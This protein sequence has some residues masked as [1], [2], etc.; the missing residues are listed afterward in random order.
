MATH[1]VDE[2]RVAICGIGGSG[3]STLMYQFLQA[4]FNTAI[5]PTIID[6]F[7]KQITVDEKPCFVEVME[8]YVLIHD[9]YRQMR[10]KNLR[11]LFHGFLLL[12]SI[13]DEESFE[14][15]KR[16]RDEIL[17]VRKCNDCPMVLVGNK[18]DLHLDRVVEAARA[19]NYANQLGIPYVETSAK[20]GVNVDQVFELIVREIRS[21]KKVGGKSCL[22]M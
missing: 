10:E 17:R 21:A 20:Q 5:D 13:V 2:F 6:I 7:G 12:F 11:E 19:Q 3:K 15:V 22:M 16:I 9:E 4:L 18:C 14:E 1:Q 8:T